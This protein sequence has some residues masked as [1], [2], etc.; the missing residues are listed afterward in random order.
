MVTPVAD[1]RL[2]VRSLWGKWSMK[3]QQASHPLLKLVT[4]SQVHGDQADRL[5]NTS[6]AEQY[7]ELQ[8]LREQLTRAQGEQQCG[9][10]RTLSVK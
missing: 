6:L 5:N 3:K 1:T 2:Q 9:T 10:G 4:H 7:A 8:R